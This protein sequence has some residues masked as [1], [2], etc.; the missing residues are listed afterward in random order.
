MRP[1]DHEYQ[2]HVA[3]YAGGSYL[4]SLRE[5][6]HWYVKHVMPKGKTYGTMHIKTIFPL[7]IEKIFGKEIDQEAV[8]LA[9]N[10]DCMVSSEAEYVQAELERRI[11]AVV[12]ANFPQIGAEIPEDFY[13]FTGMDLVINVPSAYEDQRGYFF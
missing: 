1:S 4:I 13:Q 5:P 11:L 7:L 9:L 3:P 10:L 8:D 6:L 2:L 12:L